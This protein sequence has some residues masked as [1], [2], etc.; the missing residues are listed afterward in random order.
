M[1]YYGAPKVTF[2]TLFPPEL[3]SFLRNNT[4]FLRNI[5][6]LLQIINSFLRNINSF[7]RKRPFWIEND[8]SLK[9]PVHINMKT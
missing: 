4:S 6:S 1:L 2:F 5:N 7:L 8:F 3:N 9:N